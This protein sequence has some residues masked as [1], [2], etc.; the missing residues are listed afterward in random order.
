MRGGKSRQSGCEPG[1]DFT[2]LNLSWISEFP[3][4]VISY[5]HPIVFR[6]ISSRGSSTKN[7]ESP[8]LAIVKIP[9]LEELFVSPPRET[10]AIRCFINID[11][12]IERSRCSSG[13]DSSDSR[14]KWTVVRITRG[15]NF[16]DEEQQLRAQ[17]GMKQG[18]LKRRGSGFVSTVTPLSSLPVYPRVLEESLFSMTIEFRCAK[19]R[20]EESRNRFPPDIQSSPSS[21][22]ISR[23]RAS[24]LSLSPS[25][26]L[27]PSL[28]RWI[29]RARCSPKIPRFRLGRLKENASPSTRYSR[30]LF[31]RSLNLLPPSPFSS[32]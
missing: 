30:K 13:G 4:A 26:P 8:P 9:R 27:R 6:L 23:F 2:T 15:S 29:G 17:S 12:I 31:D 7:L 25:S 21:L 28:P 14:K 11:T 3:C 22:A 24:F 32:R 20:R 1:K 5:R 10:S 18:S 19:V 16:H